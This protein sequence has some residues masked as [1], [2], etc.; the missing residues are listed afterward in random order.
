MGFDLDGFAQVEAEYA[1]DGL[2]IHD[3]ATGCEVHIEIVLVDEVDK[4]LHI[5]DGFQHDVECFHV[6]TPPF[7][8]YL[9]SSCTVSYYYGA[10]VS[11]MRKGLIME[12]S[13]RVAFITLGCKVNSSE[14]E[15]MRNLFEAAGYRSVS[16]T[17]VADVYVINTCTVTNTGDR[18]SRQ[19]IRRSRS[20]NPSA[21]V[22][23][24]GC[25]AQMAPDEVA[26]I[27]G[28]DLVLGNNQK[29]RIVELVEDLA[30]GGRRVE[31]MPSEEMTGFETLPILD[32][33]GQSRAFI[34]IQDGCNRFC[35]YCVIPYARGPVRSR[36]IPD[37]LEEAARLVKKGFP[38]VVLTGIHLTS[39]EDG[40][41]GE[42]LTGLIH[43]LGDMEGLH[44][45]RLGSLEPGFL[46]DAF[47]DTLAGSRKF[48]PHFHL[49]LQSGS[50]SVLRR[51]NRHYAPGDFLGIAKAIRARFPDASLTT[52]VMVGFPGE[53][54]REF[55]DS[56]SFCTSVGFAW[57]HVFPYSPRRGTPAAE[58]PDQVS[59]SVKDIRAAR[60]LSLAESMR[61]TFRQS[62]IGREMAVQMEQAVPGKPDWMEGFT[63]NY[64][65]VAVQAVPFRPGDCFLVRLDESIGS[66]MQGTLL[67]R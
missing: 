33:K 59:K 61:T 58:W 34:K 11:S 39:F 12:N 64:I 2:R 28:V 52:D 43:A 10:I 53:T 51:M 13:F 8:R 23:A 44:R 4:I 49:S 32:F 22:A 38:E 30:H 67:R 63:A 54:E 65:Q 9:P 27:A 48:C 40:S 21:I 55:E 26:S 62:F 15:G 37:I 57:M 25:Y 56:L 5:V 17:D 3:V 45:V 18:K 66:R 1:H 36:H 20:L 16:E 6:L 29:H 35:S 24:V 60:L 31:I 14:T 19:M 7:L 46:T 42:G 41:G 47:L 50:E